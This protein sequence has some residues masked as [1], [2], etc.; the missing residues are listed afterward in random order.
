M[1]LTE[2]LGY[3]HVALSRSDAPQ[4]VKVERASERRVDNRS[5]CSI[6]TNVCLT[7]E[8]LVNEVPKATHCSM[9]LEK[10]VEKT[11]CF[12]QKA[13]SIPSESACQPIDL[14]IISK[15]WLW[16]KSSNSSS[17][18]QLDI[19]NVWQQHVPM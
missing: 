15:V 12:Q 14:I 2:Y 4:I 16:Q 19:H 3:C 18:P 5:M 10:F 11:S 6:K 7:S 9:F 17:P 8:C 13:L 1:S